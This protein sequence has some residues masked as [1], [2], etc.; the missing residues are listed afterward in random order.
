M[1]IGSLGPGSLVGNRAKKIGERSEP[2][3]DW[4]EEEGDAASPS[5]LPTQLAS[6]ADFFFSL[7]PSNEPGPRLEHR[8]GTTAKVARGEPISEK[9]NVFL[10]LG[11]KKY[12]M[13][14]KAVR[15]LIISNF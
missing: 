8:M 15:C 6:L 13:E 11:E 2:S 1:S 5:P 9:K 10:F 4:R 3:G 14:Q 12:K 7:F